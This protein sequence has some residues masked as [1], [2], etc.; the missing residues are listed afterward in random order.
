MNRFS[1]AWPLV[2]IGVLACASAFA[3]PDRRPEEALAAMKAAGRQGADVAHVRW[4]KVRS[5]KRHTSFFFADYDPGRGL[6]QLWAF[7]EAS[8]KAWLVAERVSF[9]LTLANDARLFFVA[10]VSAD[11][12]G[13]LS[14][15]QLPQG[16]ARPV[17]A[18]VPR[19][20]LELDEDGRTGFYLA[21]LSDGAGELRALPLDSLQ[22][23]TVARG[24]SDFRLDPHADRLI[25]VEA[26]PGRG[27]VLRS[28]ALPLTADVIDLGPVKGA[29]VPSRALASR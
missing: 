16:P 12:A 10:A 23:R 3:R 19:F 5:Q 18:G 24:V 25:F 20:G 4:S 14:V 2:F 21:R 29:R 15:A 27:N 6:G 22:P 17:D 1:A 7:D 11:G 9:H 8:G 13:V 26:V 28:A